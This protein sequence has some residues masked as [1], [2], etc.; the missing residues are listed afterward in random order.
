M[1][2]TIIIA[3][4]N[5]VTV[6]QNE[7]DKW[8]T[9]DLCKVVTIAATQKDGWN[10]IDDFERSSLNNVMILSYETFKKYISNYDAGFA[11][12]AQDSI[13]LVL[14]DEAHR[15]KNKDTQLVKALKKFNGAK[16]WIGITGTPY[17][18]NLNELCNLVE[19]FRR[20]LTGHDFKRAYCK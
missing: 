2:K 15:L 13:G 10:V 3:P 7:F 16:L 14:C 9:D 6:W 1:T 20:N 17:Q 11:K 18:N 8:C 12:Y 19:F 5:A 4:K